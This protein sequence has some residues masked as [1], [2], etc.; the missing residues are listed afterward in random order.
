[1]K[2]RGNFALVLFMGA[3][4]VAGSM[5]AQQS[6]TTRADSHKPSCS[7]PTHGTNVFKILG[8]QTY[9]L[10]AASSSFVFNK[11]AYSNCDI[12][13]GDSIML[14]FGFDDDQDV[15]TVNEE[16]VKNGYM[17]STFSVPRRTPKRR[18][19]PAPAVRTGPMPNAMAGFASKAPRGSH[20]PV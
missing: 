13:F 7:S 4:L 9:A 17:V 19:I 14:K 3:M 6:P 1:M 15:C 2:T 11:V 18:S 20:F 16:G 5:A 10:C 8:N 12:E